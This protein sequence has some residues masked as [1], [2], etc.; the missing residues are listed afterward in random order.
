MTRLAVLVALLALAL[1][2]RAT[3][4]ATLLAT[5]PENGQTLQRAPAAVRVQFDDRVHVGS[6]NAAVANTTSQS[7]LAGAPQARGHTLVLPLRAHLPNGAYTVR[8]SIVS[9][10]G[11]PEEGVLAFAVGAGVPRPVLAAHT[12]TT[13]S[14]VVLRTL[15]FLGVLVG[16]GAAVFGLLARA[17]LGGRLTRPL[18]H[19][20]FFALLA[21]FLGGSGMLHDAVGG[22]RFALVLKVALLVALAGGAAAALAPT[23]PSLLYAAGGAALVLLAAPTLMGHP[24]DRDQPTL[25][26]PLV[27]LVHTAG[28]AVWLGGLAALVYVLP[29]TGEEG[30]DEAVRRFSSTALVAVAVV[31]AS[32]L[33]RA[34]ME[35]S[36]VSQVWSTSY[37][38]TLIVK[39]ALFAPLLGVGW[40]N[41]SLFL[42]AFARLRRSVAVEATVVAGIVVAV[43]VLTQLRPGVEASRA[44]TA[45]APLQAAQPP[46]LPPRNAVVDAQELGTLAVAVARTPG[47]ALVTLVSPDGTGVNGRVVAVDGA[48]ATP[49]GSGCYRA[50][51]ASG[52][53]LRVR[54]DGR[55]R[56]F[57]LPERAP[58]ATSLLRR[59]TAAYR[60]SRTIVFDETLASTPTNAQTTRFT[61][62]A[63]HSLAYTV[64][65]GPS[66][67]VIGSRR[68]DKAGP[69]APWLESSQTPLDV[70][71]PYWQAPT[72]A[73]LVA[74]NVVTFLDRRLPAWF[75]VTV[76][77]GRLRAMH[78]TA[79]AHFMTD[80][81]RAFGADVVVSPPPSR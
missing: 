78:M 51:A 5:Q 59:L 77:N 44:A 37:G 55:V 1:P 13:W 52:G 40:L 19:L 50:P 36:S 29:R 9:Q 35:L 68:W 81:Y 56:V 21:A 45:T 22:T 75:R 2:A 18:A 24:L 46:A 38:R 73:H 72:N 8:W 23:T 16:G 30:R 25:L 47:V 64:A 3:A 32:G 61:V 7:V 54:V 15:F 41:R 76:T 14:R 11:H 28:A 70:T 26:S 71:Q 17:F 58:D 67:R 31:A 34:L 66:A 4:H 48:A 33:G 53:P 60:S 79:A 12:P 49:C 27:D 80:R 69:K 63:P 20:L 74:P 6:G 10:D 39:S 57:A 42:S 43:G 62:V 65:N